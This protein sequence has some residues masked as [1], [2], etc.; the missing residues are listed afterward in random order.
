MLSNNGVPLSGQSGETTGPHPVIR[1]PV[2]FSFS[3]GNIP[4]FTVTDSNIEIHPNRLYLLF[5]PNGCG[6]STLLDLLCGL[7][8]PTTGSLEFLSS[9][10]ASLLS[11]SSSVYKS[12]RTPLLIAQWEAGVRRTFQIPIVPPMSTAFEFVHAGIRILAQESFASWILPSSRGVGFSNDSPKM[13]SKLITS[14]DAFPPSAV[15][16]S[17]SYGHRRLLTTLQ[18]LTA[19]PTLLLLDEPMANLSSEIGLRLAKMIDRTVHDV[20]EGRAALVV[21]HRPCSIADYADAV[22]TIQNRCLRMTRL[23]SGLDKKRAEIQRLLLLSLSEE[24]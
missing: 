3:Y 9:S 2:G 13:V 6:K 23:P 20:S 18:A 15:V 7:Q 21:E 1:I 5:G 8:C 4:L 14:M 24:R 17:L 19:Q 12:F 16:G 11:V 22:L 10:G